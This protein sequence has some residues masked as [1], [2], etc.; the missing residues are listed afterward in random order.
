MAVPPPNVSNDPNGLTTVR[1]FI[2]DD[3][4]YADVDNRPLSDLW[5][6]DNLLKAILDTLGSNLSIFAAKVGEDLTT[7]KGTPPAG[8]PNYLNN[9]KIYD[10]ETHTEAIGKLDQ[11][12]QHQAAYMGKQSIGSVLPIFSTHGSPSYAITDGKPLDES[13]GN[14]DAEAAR[15][16]AFLGKDSLSQFLP[17]YSGH[18]SHFAIAPNDPVRNAI[19]KL[20][21]A[22]AGAGKARFAGPSG[23]A[24]ND[25][26]NPFATVNWV[27]ALISSVQVKRS[28]GHGGTYSPN[29][30]RIYL[31]SG[32]AYNGGYYYHSA[33]FA[34]G[35]FA[36]AHG[37]L[38]V[39]NHTNTSAGYAQYSIYYT[40]GS[41]TAGVSAV[42]IS[43]MGMYSW[44]WSA[45]Q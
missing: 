23:Y 45:V 19:G 31:Y 17:D 27:N 18:T 8:P 30:Y 4:V 7:P 10:G 33:N 22:I 25:T 21:N 32:G 40:A 9:Y 16:Q 14:L 6:R 15:V 2:K 20:D 36:A 42:A 1:F 35:G 3:P 12:A 43:Q 28:G 26:T 37:S 5:E 11:D 29:Y 44:S 39:N 24:P 34:A 38:Q 13:L 41:P